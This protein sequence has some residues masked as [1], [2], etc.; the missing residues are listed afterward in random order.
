MQKLQAYKFELK[1]TPKQEKKLARFVG[2]KRFVYNK[3]LALQQQKREQGQKKLNY[4]DLC[5]E[6]TGWRHTEDTSFLQVA[7]THP[8]QQ[9]LLDLDRAFV[10]FFAGR[11][12]FPRFKKRGVN[13]S[14]RYP[15]P[16]QIKLD[17]KHERIFL[18]KLGWLRYRKS[19]DIAG[20]LKQVTVSF[21]A[22]KWYISIQ[23]ERELELPKSDNNSMVGVDVGVVRFATLS[24][25]T[26][27]F[28]INSY[29][30]HQE[31]LAREQKKLTRKSRFSAN[32]KRQVKR[33]QKVH[34]IIS[35][36][37]RDFLHK[38]STTI[39]KT[40]AVVIIEDLNVKGM[41][42]SA[43]GTLENP[44]KNVRAKSGLNR[45]ILDQGWS[46]FRR[47][48]QYK[49]DWRGGLLIAVPA[50]GTSCRCSAC[51]HVSSE[52]RVNQATFRCLACSYRENADLNA[53]NN[54][55]AAGRAVIACGENKPLGHSLKQEPAVSAVL[56]A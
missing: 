23:T 48:L 29:A 6:L 24:D 33:I 28:P 12:G 34:K 46:E 53:A 14:F 55:L 27:F 10:N 1:T 38:T 37:R 15:D 45:S 18:P 17:E 44:G 8:L 2:C 40:H 30:R 20:D 50:R 4:S 52:N 11:T 16:K 41:S 19:R 54:I 56:T 3:G 39:C 26:V 9:A 47:Q 43:A 36:I 25:G 31:K 5:K 21:R 35:D 51:G 22:G 42:A 13:E 32:W 49:L 7:P